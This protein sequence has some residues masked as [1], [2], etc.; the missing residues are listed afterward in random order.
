MGIVGKIYTNSMLTLINSRMLL[1]SEDLP[2]TIVS[3]L[4]F[5]MAPANNKNSAIETHDGDL[6]VDA[7]ART[8]VERFRT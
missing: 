2:L 7:E 8:T 4:R 3:E 1:G 6:E 5:G